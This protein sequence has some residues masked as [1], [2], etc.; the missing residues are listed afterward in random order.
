MFILC[1][2]VQ[3]ARWRTRRE[4]AQLAVAVIYKR[5]AP[6]VRTQTTLIPFLDKSCAARP[7]LRH[8]HLVRALSSFATDRRAP[9]CADSQTLARMRLPLRPNLYRTVRVVMSDGST[10]LQQSAVRQVGEM[11]PLERDVANHPVYLGLSDLTGMVDRR[12]EARLQRI[13]ERRARF[14]DDN[15]SDAKE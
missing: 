6:I 15:Y 9:P 14:E 12:E 11:L 2:A 5:A 4:I 8:A 13:A 10:F 1:N 7:G 3:G